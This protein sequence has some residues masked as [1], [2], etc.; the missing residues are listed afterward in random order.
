MNLTAVAPVKLLPVIVT[1][2]PTGP[3]AGVKLLIVGAAITVNEVALVAVPAGVV[4][5]T[6]PLVVPLATVA[7][8]CVAETTV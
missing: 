2:V 3:L 1:E 7:V 8:I 5:V 6:V 4:T